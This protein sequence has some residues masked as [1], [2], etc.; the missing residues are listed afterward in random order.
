MRG[1]VGKYPC[2]SILILDDLDIQVQHHNPPIVKNVCS[3][4]ILHSYICI[5]MGLI[6][7]HTN[8]HTNACTHSSKHACTRT[9]PVRSLQ[10]KH[11]PTTNVSDRF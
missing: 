3:L 9:L 2:F 7:K 6:H 11:P 1:R 8:T 5:H 4:T 10:D